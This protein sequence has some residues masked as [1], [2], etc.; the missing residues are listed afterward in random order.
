MGRGPPLVL[1]HGFGGG[2]G[3]W[4]GN[5]DELAKNHTVYA[6][7]VLGFGRSS[8]PAFDK[9]KENPADAAEDF[10]INSLHEWT[11]VMKLDKFDLLGHSMGGYISSVY[12]LKHPQKLSNLILAGVWPG[13]SIHFLIVVGSADL[14][15]LFFVQT[16]GESPKC[17]PIGNPSFPCVGE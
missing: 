4:L 9:A 7:D 13:A 2:L 15:F 1:V 3:I 11:N 5:L 8:R 10:F 6:I 14:G 16:P 17:L 12:A